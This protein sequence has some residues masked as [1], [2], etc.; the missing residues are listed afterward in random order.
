[1]IGICTLHQKKETLTAR[2]LC[3][4]GLQAMKSLVKNRQ[5]SWPKLYSAGLAQKPHA[6][7]SSRRGNGPVQQ[8]VLTTL[9]K[10]SKRKT[11]KK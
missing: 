10:A 3:A 9:A 1:M 4:S 5:T 8:L 11:T 6:G 7:P 2:G